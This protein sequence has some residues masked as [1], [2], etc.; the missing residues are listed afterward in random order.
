M[1]KEEVKKNILVK[2]E[3]GAWI[4]QTE[5]DTAI[6]FSSADKEAAVKFGTDVANTHN[7][8]VTIYDGK[9]PV[10]PT[11]KANILVYR[12]D[13]NWL[14]STEN[15]TAVLFA[16]PDKDPALLFAKEMADG[17]GVKVIVDDSGKS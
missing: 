9:N 8:H 2:E 16:S 5:G 14:V 11:Q 13:G 15:D 4:V 10:A 3:E 17:H 7:V 6:L 1:D 12:K